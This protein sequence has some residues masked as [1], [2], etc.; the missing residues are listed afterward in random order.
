[1]QGV[2]PSASVTAVPVVDRAEKSLVDA[3][4]GGDAGARHRFHTE[5]LPLI[6]RFDAGGREH[7]SATDD[8]LAFLFDNDRLFRRLRGYRGEA[9]LRAYLWHSILP[10]LMKQFRARLRRRR[11]ETVSIDD[12]PAAGATPGHDA[13]PAEAAAPEVT[14]ALAA[15]PID[16]RVLIKLVHVEDFEL[17][18]GELQFLAERNGWTLRTVAVRVAE[19]REAVRTREAARHARL[20]GAASAGQWIRLYEGQLRQITEDLT[21]L[22]DEDSRRQRLLA[23][24]AELQRKLAKRARQRSEHLRAAE[25]ALVTMP[26][27]LI[28]ELLRQSE[29]TT[30]VQITRVRRALAERLRAPRRPGEDQ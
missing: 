25:S 17:D 2:S 28:A 3:C 21:G 11:L 10:D 16:K 8:F 7:E 14:A 18:A 20:D 24:R 5:M 26:T 30:R 6:Y 19:A 1:M 15:L 27:A 13:P 23:R 22:E 4:V 29:S 12:R 9:P